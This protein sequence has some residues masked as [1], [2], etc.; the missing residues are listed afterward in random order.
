MTK[1][2]LSVMDVEV[3]I[4]SEDVLTKVHEAKGYVDQ[5]YA[6]IVS[7]FEK[8]ENELECLEALEGTSDDLSFEVWHLKIQLWVAMKKLPEWPMHGPSLLGTRKIP[9]G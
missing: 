6:S 7:N 1:S 4:V 8:G 3:Y 2:V 5:A 9:N